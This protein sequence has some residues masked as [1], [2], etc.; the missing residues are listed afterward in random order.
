MSNTLR[1]KSFRVCVISMVKTLPKELLNRLA[2]S[3][4]QPSEWPSGAT[5]VGIPSFDLVLLFKYLYK[6]SGL[7]SASFASCSQLSLPSHEDPFSAISRSL[8]QFIVEP[9]FLYFV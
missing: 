4:L 2:L 9:V 8:V 6:A 3:M 5:S 7:F 1:V